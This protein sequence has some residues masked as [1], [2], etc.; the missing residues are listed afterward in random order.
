MSTHA[1]RRGAG[2][3]DDLDERGLLH[4]TTDREALRELLAEPPTV[5]Y[6]GIDPSAPSLH[7]GNLIGVMVLRRF[8]EAGHRPLA[9]VGGATGMV[10][11]P[12]G[13]SDERN[14]LDAETLEANVAA[15]RQQYARLAG[16]AEADVV[17]NRDWTAPVGVIEFL[18]DVGKHVTVGQMLARESVRSR[19]RSDQGISYTEFSYMLLQAF[20]FWWLHTHRG[21]SLQVGGSDQ[22]GNIVAG[23][24]LIR[25]RSGAVAHGLT[26]PL[27][28]RADGQKFGKTADGT[29]WLTADRTLPFDLHQ[30]LLR[31]DDADVGMLL[32]RLTLLPMDAVRQITAEHGEAPERRFAQQRLADEVTAFVYGPEAVAQAN[33]AAEAL[34]GSAPLSGELLGALSGIVAEVRA[35]RDEL[36]GPEALLGLLVSSGLCGSRADARRQLRQSAISVNRARVAGSGVAADSLIDDRYLLLQRG[37]RERRLIVV[38]P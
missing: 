1:T 6:L 36:A 19:L 18:R 20:D 14:L 28:T 2:V 23:I 3:L 32:A 31:S 8:A 30:H 4:D 27:L 26:W 13:R 33:M 25:R 22:W 35:P 37:R 16:T 38:A 29:V 15:I 10:G 21:C 11:D 5:L 12:S 7:L 17:D 9:L 24:D 34:Y